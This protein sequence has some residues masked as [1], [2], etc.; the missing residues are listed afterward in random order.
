MAK[1]SASFG[2]LLQR[3]WNNHHVSLRVKDNILY[4]VQSCCPPSFME[5]R[6][7]QCTDDRPL[8]IMGYNYWVPILVL[9]GRWPRANIASA[10]VQLDQLGVAL[11]L[12]AL[13]Q[14]IDEL[15]AKIMT[16][17]THPD[18]H[19]VNI[20][21]ANKELFLAAQRDD[22]ETVGRIVVKLERNGYK[23]SAPELT[24]KGAN[25]LHY[26]LR[27][28]HKKANGYCEGDAEWREGDCKDNKWRKNNRKH[29][30]QEGDRG[31]SDSREGGRDK[32]QEMREV[33]ATGGKT[34]GRKE[35][36]G[37]V[38]K[39]KSITRTMTGRKETGKKGTTEKE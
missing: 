22:A 23:L 11:Y 5:P 25:L 34:N 27:N 35:V 15:E 31:E 2:R 33:D 32:G 18:S 13:W 6:P 12:S 21:Q 7:G 3:L 14:D 38:T 26:T 17:H 28:G 1:A 9:T 30:M 24:E 20:Q 39:R 4:T 10:V 36:R 8:V 19:A 29:D 16:T 37:D